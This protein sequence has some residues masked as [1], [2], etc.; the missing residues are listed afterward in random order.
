RCRTAAPARH[1][2]RRRTNREPD[3]HA[4]YHAGGV[5]V[6]RPLP[7]VVQTQMVGK[8]CRPLRYARS[9]FGGVSMSA[10][11]SKVGNHGDVLAFAALAF[12]GACTVGPN[13]VKRVADIP[14][15]FKES[16]GWKAAQPRDQ[17]LR[18][19]WW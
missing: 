10:I 7:P 4:L 12:L 18:G 11:R 19:N 16:E 8:R 14:T 17:E 9:G 1:L 3:A 13:Y 2:D 5:S 6:S 15:A